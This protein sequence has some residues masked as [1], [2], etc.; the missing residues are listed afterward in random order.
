M[1]ADNAT[2]N[3]FARSVLAGVAISIGCVVFLRV[4][5]V[6][7]AV[8]FAFGLLTCVHFKLPLYTGTAGFVTD[9]RGLGEL[10]V[11]LGGN[12]V[13]CLLMALAMRS[14]IEG[15][16]DLAGGVSAKRMVMQPWQILIL[17]C[18]CGFIMT[19]AV[20]FARAG[21][22]L[23]LIFGVPVFILCG[24]VHSI[25]D[26]FYILASPMSVL[27]S[28]PFMVGCNYV[29]A[30]AGNFVGCNLYRILCRRLTYP[31]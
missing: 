5:G 7:G 3:V 23:P 16:S 4:G 29:M 27:G 15:I 26:A 21:S 19:T 18:L 6:E 24:F 14:S 30:V 25:A 12:I 28:D 22:F 1:L 2:R 31:E 11:I 9:R 17:S 20:K 8:L 10:F 13:G